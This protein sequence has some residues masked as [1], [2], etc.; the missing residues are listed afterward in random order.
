MSHPLPERFGIPLWFC[1]YPQEALAL[2]VE[3]GAA[4]PEFAVDA[5]VAPGAASAS[6]SRPAPPSAA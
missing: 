1:Y 2:I 3:R 6:A 5:A 4:R